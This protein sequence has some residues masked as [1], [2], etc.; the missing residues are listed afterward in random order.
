MARN[1]S[2]AIVVC[3]TTDTV[4]NISRRGSRTLHRK[5]PNGHPTNASMILRGAP[6]EATARSPTAMFTMR[7]LQGV[8]ISGQR[9]TV[10]TMIEL[11]RTPKK[12]TPEKRIAKAVIYVCSYESTSNPIV[13][14]GNDCADVFSGE[15][16]EIF[17]KT[18]E[19]GEAIVFFGLNCFQS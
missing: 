2:R 11:S 5:F 16:E 3:V 17:H 15:G 9:Y 18:V 14:V 19:V 13:G 1:L 6:K 8:L 12:I 10:K 4:T 7:R